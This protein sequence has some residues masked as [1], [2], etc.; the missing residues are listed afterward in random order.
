MVARVGDEEVATLGQSDSY[1]RMKAGCI[2][3][4]IDGSG[5]A[6]CPSQSGDHARIADFANRVSPRVRDVHVAMVIDGNSTGG[7]ESCEIAG[8]IE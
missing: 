7:I 6:R 8:S 3:C 2:A 5:Y 4:S 1:R